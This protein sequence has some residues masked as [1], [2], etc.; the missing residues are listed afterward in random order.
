MEDS[1]LTKEEIDELTSNLNKY[2][3]KVKVT[4]NEK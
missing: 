3:K 1:V 4:N 2:S